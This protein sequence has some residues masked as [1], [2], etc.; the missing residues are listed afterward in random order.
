MHCHL[1][2]VDRIFQQPAESRE[3][4]RVTLRMC[5]KLEK[6]C[7]IWNVVLLSSPVLISSAKMTLLGLHSRVEIGTVCIHS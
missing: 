7:T 4:R 2:L 6:P 5:A 3:V 1:Q